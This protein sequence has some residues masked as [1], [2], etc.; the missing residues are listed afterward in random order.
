M[1]FSFECHSPLLTLFRWHDGNHR[2][3]S[4][5]GS[6]LSQGQWRGNGARGGFGLYRNFWRISYP[7]WVVTEAKVTFNTLTISLEKIQR[8]ITPTTVVH[9]LIWLFGLHHAEEA[10]KCLVI[11][12]H[13]GT[14]ML[15]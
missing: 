5:H 14:S 12:A 9:H 13:Q 2:E 3:F 10:V 7:W 6:H 15:T 4:H 11:L 8:V 1:V